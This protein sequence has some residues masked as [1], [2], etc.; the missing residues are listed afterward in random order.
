MYFGGA[1]AGNLLFKGKVACVVTRDSV[2]SQ[3][4][5]SGMSGYL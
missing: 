1:G 5:V 3:Y 2:I 4:C